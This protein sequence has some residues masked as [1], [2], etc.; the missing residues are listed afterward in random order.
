VP[1]FVTLCL[2]VFGCAC[3]CYAVAIFVTLCLSLLRCACL[4]YA[5]PVFVTCACPCSAVPVFA[6]LCLSVLGCAC[7]CYVVPN[8]VK[9]WWPLCVPRLFRNRIL[10]LIPLYS[11]GRAGR[12]ESG[13]VMRECTHFAA[14]VRRIFFRPRRELVP[15]WLRQFDRSRQKPLSIVI[16]FNWTNFDGE[17]EAPET[18]CMKP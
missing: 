3:L 7:L 6:T 15:S 8:R 9:L 18:N 14:F 5:V 10:T 1:V 4:C 12:A 2:S 17:V 13:L 16:L 11:L